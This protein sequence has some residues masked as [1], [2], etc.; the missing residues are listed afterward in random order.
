MGGDECPK[1]QWKGDPRTQ[2]VIAERGLAD[3]N[4]LQSWFITRIAAHVA[5]RGRRVFGWDEILEGEL[6]PGVA[7]ASWRGLTGAV[8]A[9]RR[10]FDV[11]SCPDDQVYLDYRQSEHPDEPIPVPVPVTLADAY[12]FDPVPDGLSD[13]Q[14]AR[15]LGGQANLWSEHMDTPRMVDYYAFPRLCAVAEAL[16]CGPG[17]R[18]FD[19]F[20]SRLYDAHLPRLDAIGVE[21]RPRTGPL[22][23][24]TR[25][26]VVGAPATK[27]DR[28]AH[29][30]RRVAAIRS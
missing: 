25:P 28:E 22:P 12:A 29:T 20:S 9:A 15:V 4:A 18:D 3:E 30:N 24:Q 2:E 11:V 1:E 10:G 16:W 5:E 21:Y 14:A 7:V 23:W 13:E 19:E 6:P 27:A 26:G 8:T 17:R